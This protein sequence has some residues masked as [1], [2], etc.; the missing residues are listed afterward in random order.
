[1]V[2]DKLAAARRVLAGSPLISVIP[3]RLPS[4]RQWRDRPRSTVVA[5]D[6]PAGSWRIKGGRTSRDDLTGAAE[7]ADGATAI[8]ETD[9]H[10]LAGERFLPH[11]DGARHEQCFDTVRS[12]RPQDAR[13]HF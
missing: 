11:M 7:Q 9:L 1:M 4:L 5:S 6:V 13:I 8:K 12:V 3:F 10:V 2:P